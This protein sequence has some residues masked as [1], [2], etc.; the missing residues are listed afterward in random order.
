MPT[1]VFLTLASFALLSYVPDPADDPELVRVLG[2]EGVEELRR[3][4]FLDL[5]RFFNPKPTDVRARVSEIV[6]QFV[7]DDFGSERAHLMLQQLGGAALPSLIPKLDALDPESRT[8]VALGLV[9]LAERMG[10][11]SEEPRD[12]ERALAFWARFWA[13][14]ESDFR[15]ASARRAVR[16]FALKATTMREAE[17]RILD[18]YALGELFVLLGEIVPEGD[19]DTQRRLV[20]LAAQITGRPD[21]IDEN[22]SAEDARACSYRWL[23][24]W[25]ANRANYAVYDGPSR[26]AAVIVDTQYARWFERMLSLRLGTGADGV[27]ILDKLKERAPRTLTIAFLAVFLAYL[28]A[29]PLGIVS[30]LRHRLPFHH[31]LFGLVLLSH[32]VPTACFALLVAFVFPPSGESLVLPAL[33]LSL[34]FIASPARHQHTRLVE[35]LQ[36]DYIRAAKSRGISTLRIVSSHALRGTLGSMITLFS[37]DLPAALAGSFVVEKVFGIQGLGEE[38]VRAVQMRDVA[39]L[40]TM[41]FG[42]ATIGALTL[43][44]SDVALSLVDP[45][46]RSG[47]LRG[48][49]ALE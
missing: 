1:L 19:L 9:P 3:S 28:V 13:D 34:A 32:A 24:W 35:I 37:L 41:G 17:L 4:R 18:T 12:P 20:D 36:L 40:M 43:L 10:I 15:P 14:R 5:P 22:A 11:S 44:A 29:L 25:L 21:T 38:T 46:V 48:K 49:T 33:V 23:D 7:E 39:W 30:A 16:R 42:A 31:G 8:R 26:L 6:D 47:L 27:A 2:E 45:R